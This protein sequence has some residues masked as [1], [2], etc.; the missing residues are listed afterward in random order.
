MILSGKRLKL[1][2]G[3]VGRVGEYRVPG[4]PLVYQPVKINFE[5]TIF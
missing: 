2:Y 3:R 4:T 5:P 1:Y